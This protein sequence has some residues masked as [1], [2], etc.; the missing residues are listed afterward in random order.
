MSPAV[1]LTAR[2]AGRG[3]ALRTLLQRQTLHLRYEEFNSADE[4]RPAELAHT[5]AWLQAL[6]TTA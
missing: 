3:A 6:S 4:I 1:D 5:V 2:Q